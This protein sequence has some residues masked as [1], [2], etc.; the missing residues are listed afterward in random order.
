MAIVDRRG[1][2][3]SATDPAQASD[4][5]PGLAMK[6]A[7]AMATTGANIALTGLQV[8]D[9]I[10]TIAA[11]RVLV[12]D[13]TDPTQNGLYNASTGNWTRTTDADSNTE[14]APGLQV[15]VMNGTLNAG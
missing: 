1:V 13:Q 10:A 15:A 11:D 2:V 14:F 7:A 5:N 3:V 4:P 9:G 8:I 6:T 12:K